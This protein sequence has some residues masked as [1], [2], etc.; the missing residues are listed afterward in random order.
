MIDALSA[1]PVRLLEQLDEV[2]DAPSDGV[3]GQIVAASE[4][5]DAL[6]RQAAVEALGRLGQSPD[7]ALLGDASKMVQRTAAWAA[8][9]AHSRHEEMPAADI[10]HALRSTNDRTRWG[11]TRIFAAHFAALARKPELS[12][13]LC[14]LLDDPATAIRMNAVKGLWQFWFWSPDA[15]A[16]ER[17]EDTLLAALSA[18]QHT[19]VEENLHHAVYNLADENI[20]YLYNNWVPLL[21]RQEDR[22]RV[23]RGRLAVEDRLANKFAAILEHGSTMQKKELL[24]ALTE[25]PLRRADVYDLDADSTKLAPPVYNRIGNDIEQIAFFGQTADRISRSLSPLLDSP[26]ADL[27]RAAARAVLMVR[28]TRFADANRV[29]GPPGEDT[30]QIIAR[31]DAIPEAA[32]VAQALKP[33][34]VTAT[35]A[36]GPAPAKPKLDEAFFR[37]YVQPILEKRGK[38]GYAC[39]QCHATHTLFNA[40]YATALNVVDAANPEKSLILLKPTSSSESEGIAGGSAVAHG[41][42]VRWTKD[43]PEY[44]TILQWIK[45]A[46]Q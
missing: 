19:W 12:E 24:I 7:L 11:A 42:G 17:I 13:A 29:A 6:I 38:D 31:I 44:S 14:K 43:S 34:P 18:P 36:S 23:V 9:Q 35:V 45:G 4:S 28:E 27:R 40:T 2:W 41:G 22:E 8:R 1:D 32:D 39:V 16:K 33:A 21:A 10:I 20:R 3:R 25:L 26:D 15:A 46:K 5:N 37:G 30:K